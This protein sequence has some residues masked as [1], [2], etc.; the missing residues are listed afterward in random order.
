MRPGSRKFGIRATITSESCMSLL[1]NR[2]SSKLPRLPGVPLVTPPKFGSQRNMFPGAL[3]HNTIA[4]ER[5][6]NVGERIAALQHLVSP[7]ETR[8]NRNLDAE[9]GSLDTA[10][11]LLEA[12]EYIHFLHDQVKLAALIGEVV[13]AR[14]I[15]HVGSLTNLAKCPSSTLQILDA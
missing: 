15:S 7:Y 8:S 5:K 10:S 11:V 14:L 12:M 13:G 4:Q 3:L 6:E 1:A 2:M 9:R